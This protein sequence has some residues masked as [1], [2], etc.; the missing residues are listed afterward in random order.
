MYLMLAQSKQLYQN[1]LNQSLSKICLYTLHNFCI[2]VYSKLLVGLPEFSG[3][4]YDCGSFCTKSLYIV[5]IQQVL[6]FPFG[7]LHEDISAIVVEPAVYKDGYLL[8]YRLNIGRLPS[9]VQ[10]K[11]GTVTFS[12]IRKTQNGYLLR[13]RLNIGRILSLV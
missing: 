3:S 10:V 5:Y 9:L 12:G 6:L 13:Y 4:H 1:F 11:H 2:L 8:R 7:R